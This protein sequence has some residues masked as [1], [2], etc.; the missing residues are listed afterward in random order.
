MTNRS[1]APCC[2]SLV[3]VTVTFPVATPVTSP[4]ELTVA[5]VVSELDHETVRPDSKRP[6]ASNVVAVNGCAMPTYAKPDDG[7]T[8]TRATSTGAGYV[9]GVAAESP[10]QAAAHDDGTTSD[11]PAIAGTPN[12]C[13][14]TLSTWERVSGSVVTVSHNSRAVDGVTLH[15]IVSFGAAGAIRAARSRRRQ[16]ATRKAA[17]AIRYRR[18]L[19][20]FRRHMMKIASLAS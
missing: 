12:M 3:A 8:S 10:P 4:L 11:R 1:V 2:P 5:L 16:S 9:G 13:S 6:A 19:A 14:R 17:Y 18:M 20:R 7:V 15:R